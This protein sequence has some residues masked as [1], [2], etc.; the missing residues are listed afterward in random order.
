MTNYFNKL[1]SK[2]RKDDIFTQSAA[3][4]LYTSF[5][6]APLVI[7]LISFLSSLHLDLQL[8]LVA[9]VKSLVGLEAANV[10]TAIIEKAEERKDLS[11]VGGWIGSLTLLFSASVIFAHL[12]TALNKI[13]HTP[14]L[15]H[16][17]KHWTAE[18][19]HFISKRMISFGIVLSFIF[20]SI[21]SLMISSLLSL[22]MSSQQG[23]FGEVLNMIFSLVL[24]TTLFSAIF[25]WMP[26]KSIPNWAVLRAGFLTGIL[27][28]VGK[29]LIGLYLGQTAVGSAYGAAGSFILLLLWVYY[30]SLIIFV[31]AEIASIRLDSV[32]AP[33]SASASAISRKQFALHFPKPFPDGPWLPWPFW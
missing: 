15:P 16:D 6:L 33:A 10:L 32:P 22:V 12:Q 2:I 29:T 9:Q 5:S 26:D 11:T 7:L 1:I 28:M 3:L 27:F 18:L 24:F 21:V 17:N 31:G 20:I 14:P 30:S 19:R 4:A 25:K 23:F 8:H 13:F